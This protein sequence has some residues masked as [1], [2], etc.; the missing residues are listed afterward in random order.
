M[1]NEYGLISTCRERC[2]ITKFSST[3]HSFRT[4][5]LLIFIA[6]KVPWG[7]GPFERWCHPT[8]SLAEP[9][10]RWGGPGVRTN[11]TKS[12]IL[13]NELHLFKIVCTNHTLKNLYTCQNWKLLNYFNYLCLLALHYNKQELCCYCRFILIFIVQDTFQLSNCPNPETRIRHSL[14]SNPS[15]LINRIW[16]HLRWWWWRKTTCS[17]KL[18]HQDMK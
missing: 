11:G 1:L 13:L 5:T 10:R 9:Q 6:I 12:K 2:P 17:K 16:H 4:S 8:S 3:L 14:L 7:V 15:I 18:I